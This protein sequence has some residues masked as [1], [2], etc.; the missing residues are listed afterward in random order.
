MPRVHAVHLARLDR[1]DEPRILRARAGAPVRRL[2]VVDELGNRPVTVA[3]GE[4]P[5]VFELATDPGSLAG[6]VAADPCIESDIHT[7]RLSRI[8]RRE[9]A[10]WLPSAR[11]D[12]GRDP[13]ALGGE[14]PQVRGAGPPPR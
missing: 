9:P 5:Q 7:H 4:R 6:P 1:L 11:G 2:I 13:G 14:H 8:R 10:R 3:R 12:T